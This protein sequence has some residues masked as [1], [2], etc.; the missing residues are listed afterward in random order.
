[1][2]A[3]D[4][5]PRFMRWLVLPALVASLLV[6]A[7]PHAQAD[8]KSDLNKAMEQQK[9]LQQQKQ[10]AESELSQIEIDARDAAAQLTAV[11]KEL[12]AANSELV[13]INSRVTQATAELQQVEGD[14]KVAQVQFNQR[15]ETLAHRVRAIN[16]EGRV[17]Y[18]AVLLGSNSFSDFVSRFDM[19]KAVVKQDSKLFDQITAD[20]K[21]LEQKQAEAAGHRNQLVALQ[22]RAVENRSTVEVKRAERQTVSRTLDSRMR[23]VQ[24]QLQQNDLKSQ[25]TADAIW[26]IQKEMNRKPASSSGGF[27]PDPPTKSAVITDTFGPR[28]HPILHIPRMHY[29]TDFAVNMGTPVYAIESGTVIV[30]HW[31]DAFGNLVVIDHGGGFA[32]WYGHASKLLV[33]EGQKV[34]KGQQITEAGSTG[35]STGPH[36]HLEI[37]VNGTP[38]DPMIYIHCCQ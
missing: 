9:A 29:G 28:M 18:L 35:W 38:V 16:E 31:D 2:R 22:S 27:N 11:E 5:F 12:A 33:S 20:K 17:N 30:A 37:H 10:Q 7:A 13:V 1:M 8:S 23:Q 34:E 3:R 36:L 24:T 4:G 25:Q 32:S 19:L 26:Q 15:K 21:A 14:V 6:Q